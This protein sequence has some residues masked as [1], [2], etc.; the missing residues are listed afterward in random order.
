MS[1]KKTQKNKRAC[2][3]IMGARY[4]EKSCPQ[5]IFDGCQEEKFDYL[6]G[7]NRKS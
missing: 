6:R 5:K 1:C 2:G 7:S 4:K 3:P